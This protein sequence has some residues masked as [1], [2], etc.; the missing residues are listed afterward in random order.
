[1]PLS[2]SNVSAVFDRQSV[3]DM[4][5]GELEFVHELVEMFLADLPQH[6]GNIRGGLS[7]GNPDQV[8]KVAHRLKTSVGNLGGRRAQPCVIEL[9]QLARSGTLNG[10]DP[11]F[12]QCERELQTFE[13][14]LRDFLAE[15]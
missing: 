11:L 10:A 14:T 15:T 6:L 3:L 13:Q 8:Q 4:V 2:E 7:A 5:D 9:E 12:A 1:M